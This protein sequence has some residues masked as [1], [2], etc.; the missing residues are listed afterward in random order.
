MNKS[1]F[2]KYTNSQIMDNI[3]LNKKI[4]RSYLE[5]HERDNVTPVVI[6]HH[7]LFSKETLDRLS[8]ALSNYSE[9]KKGRIRFLLKHKVFYRPDMKER[10][11][12]LNVI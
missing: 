7:K 11:R 5:L 4:I 9:L 3:Y 8:L 2:K 1:I 10:L 6:Q 12:L